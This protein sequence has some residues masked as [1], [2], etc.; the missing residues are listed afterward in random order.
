MKYGSASAKPASRRLDPTRLFFVLLRVL[1]LV[2]VLVVVLMLVLKTS[3][4]M[5]FAP[6]SSNV[7]GHTFC[8]LCL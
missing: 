6:S 1:V 7:S 8:G 3:D 2:P 4:V 5:T